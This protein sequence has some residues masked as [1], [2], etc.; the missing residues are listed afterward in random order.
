[1][2]CSICLIHDNDTFLFKHYCGQFH[3]HQ[4]CL[5]QWSNLHPDI[6]FICRQPIPQPPSLLSYLLFGPRASIFSSF[7]H[8]NHY[9]N[10]NNPHYVFFLS[11]NIFFSYLLFLS[12]IYLNKHLL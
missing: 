12:I 3:V 6:C 9:N 4:S 2:E 7:F 1:M 11:R 5:D 10:N 8:Y